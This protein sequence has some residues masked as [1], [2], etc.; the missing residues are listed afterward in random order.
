MLDSLLLSYFLSSPHTV[1]SPTNSTNN[2]KVTDACLENLLIQCYY[3]FC[4][5][6]PFPPFHHDGDI[7]LSC[8]AILTARSSMLSDLSRPFQHMLNAC[9]GLGLCAVCGYIH[10]T[11]FNFVFKFPSITHRLRLL[12]LSSVFFFVILISHSLPLLVGPCVLGCL[13]DEE[14]ISTRRSESLFLSLSLSTSRF[15]CFAS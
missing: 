4:F 6:S 11:I 7:V 14:M 12:S 15:V 9:Q 1:P 5:F 13:S 3:N 2:N 8:R 10:F